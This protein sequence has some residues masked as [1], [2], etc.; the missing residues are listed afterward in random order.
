MKRI[1]VT[2]GS[3]MLGSAVVRSLAGHSCVVLAPSSREVDLLNAR[4]IHEYILDSSPDAIVHAAGKV[5]GIAANISEPTSFL[6]ENMMMGMNLVK[7]ASTIGVPELINIGSSC[8]YPRDVEGLLTE[9]LLL[10]GGLEPTNEGYALAKIATDKYCQFAR[11]ELGLA[12][13]TLIP[14]NLYGPGDHFDSARGHLI[15]AAILKI[16]TAAQRG[17]ESVDVWGSGT[18]RREFT[19]V[20]DVADWI[21]SIAATRVPKEFPSRMNVGVGVDHTVNE[22]Y[23][24]IAEIIRYNGVLKN[25][26]SKPEGMRRKLMDSSLAASFGWAPTTAL[27]EGLRLTLDFFETQVRNS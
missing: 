24:A 5:G 21:A 17:D 10:T 15:A 2:G 13:I 6:Y 3:G 4:S 20:D 8:M 9:D 22:F 7:V 27:R 19:Y 23:R 25:D 18:A 14:S 11:S 1:L 26:R 16:W 12:Y